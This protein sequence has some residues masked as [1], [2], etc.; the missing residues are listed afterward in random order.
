MSEIQVPETPHERKVTWSLMAAV[1]AF[2]VLMSCIVLWVMTS[3]IREQRSS[4]GPVTTTGPLVT[5]TIALPAQAPTQVPTSTSTVQSEVDIGP[6]LVAATWTPPPGPKRYV[7]FV[8]WK[9]KPNKITLGECIQITWKT[10]FAA[11]L[12]LYR[13]GELFVDRAPAATTLQDCPK[14]LGYVS[15][16]LVGWNHVGESNWVQLQVRVLEAP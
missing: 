13:N 16:R 14:K 5:A 1:V 3:L 6:T 7:R 10:E 9:V 12:Q 11:S 4:I 2:V 15:Y 8:S